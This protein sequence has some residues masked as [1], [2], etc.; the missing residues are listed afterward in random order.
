M[1]LPEAIDQARRSIVQIQAQGPAGGSTLGSGFLV[2]ETY[3][4]T[5][6][7]VID[8]VDL[9]GGQ[10]LIVGFALPDVDTPELSVR[11]SFIGTNANV[12]DV[13]AEQ[14]LALLSVPGAAGLPAAIQIGDR[15]VHAYRTPARLSTSPLREGT[16][17]AVS[18]YPLNEPS[19]VTTAGILASSFSLHEQGGGLRERYLADCTANP[20][21]SGGPVYAVSD[22]AVVGVCVAG[23]LAP[24]VGGQGLH[25]AAGL[26]VIVPVQEV[27]ALLERNG[28][29][30]AAPETRRSTSKQRQ[31][32]KHKRR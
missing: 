31:P 11:G 29:A 28:L 19:L 13:N 15:A 7:H 24:I 10:T 17:I 20:G 30:P 27:V 12:V 2:T 32:R 18:G 26:T 6:K 16:A 9:G 5:A 8:A 4:V 3:V 22:A 21:N 23:K 1:R 14:D 25:A